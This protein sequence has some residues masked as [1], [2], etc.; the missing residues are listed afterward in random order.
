MADVVQ[1]AAVVNKP[2]QLKA[3]AGTLVRRWAL[4]EISSALKPRGQGGLTPAGI[5]AELLD[6]AKNPP[7]DADL[8]ALAPTL[9]QA[10]E[11]VRAVAEA[12]PDYHKEYTPKPGAPDKWTYLADDMKRGSDDLMAAVKAN[13]V[14]GVQRA[15][16]SSTRVA[17][18]ATRRTAEMTPL[19]NLLRLVDVL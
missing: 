11:M 14:P 10:A 3:R 4:D 5:E 7:T 8:P 17:S 18:T 15:S 13:D 6:L 2:E 12:T 9:Q 16:T 19:G 1:A